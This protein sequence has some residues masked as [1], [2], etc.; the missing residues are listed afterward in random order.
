MGE[1][2]TSDESLDKDTTSRSLKL[3]GDMVRKFFISTM[4]I[5]RLCCKKKKTK[6]GE[7]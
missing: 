5:F 1:K 7:E 6:E 3:K 4:K 2:K